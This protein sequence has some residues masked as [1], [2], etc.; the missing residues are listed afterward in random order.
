ME[1]I[2]YQRD[3]RAEQRRQR[4]DQE[5]AVAIQAQRQLED[6]IY[7]REKKLEEA[8]EAELKRKVGREKLLVEH[9]A[10]RERE[11]ELKRERLVSKA[12]GFQDKTVF[13]AQEH[14]A[15]EARRRHFLEVEERRLR[16]QA[17]RQQL[18]EQ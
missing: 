8:K 14:N 7:A 4:A 2:Q 10:L 3:L 5:K 12:M 16:S 1:D 6:K 18:E 17:N 15:E 9:R 13:E 11:K